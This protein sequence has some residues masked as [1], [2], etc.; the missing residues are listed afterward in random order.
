MS[1]YKQ[2]YQDSLGEWRNPYAY[3]ET[4]ECQC[5]GKPW[6]AGR[7]HSPRRLSSEWFPQYCTQCW[8]KVDP[9]FKARKNSRR[10]EKHNSDWRYREAYNAQRRKKYAE[11]KENDPEAYREFMDKKNAYQRQWY[12]SRPKE[13]H[14][15][16][17]EFRR[18]RFHN[19][20]YFREIR[21]SYNRERYKEI[22]NSPKKWAAY[23][24][25]QREYRRRYKAKFQSKS[26][27]SEAKDSG[28]N[29]DL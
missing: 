10:K 21:L 17:R 23:Q 6:G 4:V 7:A 1:S 28:R 13:W 15:K 2:A 20:E 5:C 14:D 29:D 9:E 8:K 11:L 22:K 26:E 25:K 27:E 18:W 3:K 24:V 19:D 16:E 12:A